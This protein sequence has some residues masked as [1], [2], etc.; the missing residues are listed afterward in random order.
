[1]SGYAIMNFG[2]HRFTTMGSGVLKKLKSR[3]KG[4]TR[5][6]VWQDIKLLYVRI[7]KNA[8]TSIRHSIEGGIQARMSA[9]KIMDLK[10]DW[11]TFSFVRNPWARLVSLYRQK[12][13]SNATS[14]RM[15][16]GVY[17]GFLEHNIPVHQNMSFDDFCRTVCDFPDDMTDKHLRSQS[18][19]LIRNG[20]PIVQVIGKVE[21]LDDDWKA[22]MDLKQ[23]NV[24]MD[25]LNST[26]RDHYS[27]YFSDK[28]LIKLV[29]DRYAEDV[30]NF[31]YEFSTDNS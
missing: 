30:R 12:A 3:W 15:V 26:S 19:F 7:P 8:N 2:R 28:T 14:R 13:S 22:I 23:L 18:S 6:I 31:N 16:N 17:E 27:D 21:K 25:H 11:V 4:D 10:D 1:M 5:V 29:G 20:K 24:K 9:S